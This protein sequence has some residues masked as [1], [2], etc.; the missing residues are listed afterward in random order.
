M[1]VVRFDEAPSYTA[2][3]HFDM[4]MPRLQGREAGRSSEE[5][6]TS[7]WTARLR[8]RTERQPWSSLQGIAAVLLPARIGS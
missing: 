7:C 1:H 5:K 6:C 2:P 4:T 8:Y 3:G